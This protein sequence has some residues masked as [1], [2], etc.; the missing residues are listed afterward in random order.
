MSDNVRIMVGNQSQ[1]TG[2]ND[3]CPCGSGK[4]YKRCCLSNEIPLPT[5]FESP[6][7][8]QREASDRL[9]PALLKLAARELGEDLLL[10]WSEFNQVPFPEPIS[11]F[12]N[13]ECIFNPYLIFD[14]DSD[15]SLRRRSGKPRAGLVVAMYLEKNGPR[16]TELEIQILIQAIS[17][18]VSFY[19]VVHCNP[20][21]SAVFKDVLIGGET[22]VEE[23]SATKW[24]RPGDLAYGQIW[25]LP[26]VATIGRLGPRLI[27]PEQKQWILE[28]RARLRQKIAKKNRDLNAEDLLRYREEIR[29]VYLDIRDS[30]LRPKMLTNTDGEPFVLHKLT[31]RIGSAQLAFDALAS[32]SWS[33]DKEDLLEDAERDADGLLVSIE[34]DWLGKGNKLHKDWDN[35]ILGHLNI[36]GRTLVV[37]VNSENRAKRIREEI[38]KRLGLHATHLSTTTETIEMDPARLSKHGQAATP[39]TGAG[40]PELTPEMQKQFAGYMQQQVEA[41]IHQNV[42]ALGG[43]T[44]L[45][46]VGDPDGKEM[47]EALL[48][49]WERHFE[50]P[51]GPGSFKPDIDA[52][53]RLLNLPVAIGTVIH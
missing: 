37:D 46:A 9:T 52:V 50:G 36:S 15:A 47:V 31:F 39:K 24:M 33:N 30:A 10:A 35:T 5:S 19:E 14:W 45:E 20:G 44:P 4:K 25:K 16:L 41:W 48:L 32:L 23:H 3:P 49:G 40:I 6:W 13:E 28:L 43:R 1:T 53:R 12:E 8:R 26:E 11:K 18:P 29:T 22:E 7:S 51:A 2:R 27:R 21:R 42:P 38:E 34:F 17:Q